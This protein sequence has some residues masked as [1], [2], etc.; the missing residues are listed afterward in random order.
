MVCIILLLFTS[1]VTTLL[2]MLTKVCY[3]NALGVVFP[4]VCPVAVSP[5]S[6]SEGS[7]STFRPRTIC[8]CFVSTTVHIITSLNRDKS[9]I[10]SRRDPHD[11]SATTNKPCKLWDLCTLFFLKFSAID[12]RFHK[13]FP[14]HHFQPTCTS[15]IPLE[16][17]SQAFQLENNFAKISPKYD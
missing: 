10:N 9:T 5:P 8:L 13:R 12:L 3:N 15:D 7:N 4:N 6:S 16:R 11:P 14:L 1:S 17:T 2:N